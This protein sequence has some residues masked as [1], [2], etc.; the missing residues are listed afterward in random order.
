MSMIDA[1]DKMVVEHRAED[2]RA[3]TAQYATDMLDAEGDRGEFGV[4]EVTLTAAFRFVALEC[5]NRSKRPASNG[6]FL[7]DASRNQ[8]RSALENLRS[9][10]NVDFSRRSSL[11]RV[12]YPITLDLGWKFI[13]SCAI[14]AA[15][16]SI[17]DNEEPLRPAADELTVDC[18]I[19]HGDVFKLV[20]AASKS[21][22]V[23]TAVVGG[24]RTTE[25][26]LMMVKNGIDI[27]FVRSVLPAP[28]TAVEGN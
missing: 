28:P 18:G 26:A 8:T 6:N 21:P 14:A 13:D 3:A 16:E 15:L 11:G 19:A 4:T 5:Y 9:N 2:F 25:E 17:G 20:L 23:E 24:A 10:V 7:S 1:V 22:A 27:E 12:Q